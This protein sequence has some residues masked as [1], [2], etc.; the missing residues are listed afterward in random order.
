MHR[1]QANHPLSIG[2]INLA[3]ARNDAL[4]TIYVVVQHNTGKKAAKKGVHT[5]LTGS[6]PWNVGESAN[7][8]TGTLGPWDASQPGDAPAPPGH[9]NKYFDLR[10]L[11]LGQHIEV[12][13]LQSADTVQKAICCFYKLPIPDPSDPNT[14]PGV[15][16]NAQNSW[17]VGTEF[18]VLRLGDD[19]SNGGGGELARRPI[20][21]AI[22]E[23]ADDPKSDSGYMLNVQIVF[24]DPNLYALRIT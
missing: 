16:Y 1:R 9:G 4:E 6:F 14:K 17:L 5:T 18:G 22:V 10:L 11:A 19:K 8:D 2:P 13:G 3:I 20:G 7:G 15:S 21:R 24:D 12:A 23:S